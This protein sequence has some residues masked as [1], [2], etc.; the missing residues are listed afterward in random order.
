M[1][2]SSLRGSIHVH[3]TAGAG[4]VLRLPRALQLLPALQAL[5]AAQA[6]L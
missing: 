2:A 5:R 4:H 6:N 3:V 1:E